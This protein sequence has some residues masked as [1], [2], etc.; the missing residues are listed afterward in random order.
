MRE[1]APSDSMWYLDSGCSNH[2]T[3]RA[4][5]FASLSMCTTGGAVTIG[6][7]KKCKVIVK[8]TIGK[9]PFTTLENVDLVEGLIHILLSIS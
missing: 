1:A 5:L 7:G 3:G 4:D 8:V 2:I 6:D 9:H